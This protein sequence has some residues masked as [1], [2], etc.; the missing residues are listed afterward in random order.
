MK[1]VQFKII[2]VVLIF[3]FAISCASYDAV[4]IPKL[5]PDFAVNS[6]KMNNVTCSV[7]VFT[8]D[9]CRRYFDKNHIQ[10]LME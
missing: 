4:S 5:Q 10:L 7:K 1:W 2:S 3:I 9:D 8:Q 6:Q